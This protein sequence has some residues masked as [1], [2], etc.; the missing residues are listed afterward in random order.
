MP[1]CIK[2]GE[3]C[4]LA[5]E[6]IQDIYCIN[7]DLDTKLCKI[8]GNH[9]GAYCGTVNG[10]DFHCHKR[11]DSLIILECVQTPKGILER[12]IKKDKFERR[13]NEWN[14]I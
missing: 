10:K 4:K 6:G 12:G 11:E 7:L 2:C 9:I 14:L 8:Y 13:C 3:C 5:H 1:E